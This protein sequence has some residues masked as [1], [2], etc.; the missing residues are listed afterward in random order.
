MDALKAPAL[1]ARPLEALCLAAMLTY[2]LQRLIV[3]AA[4]L[5]VASMVVFAVIEI[6][7]GNA[8]Q[9]LLGATATPEAV[10]ALAHQARS[11]SAGAVRYAAWIGGALHG[12]FG[13]SYAYRTPIA[14]MI[15]ASLMISAPLAALAMAISAAIALARASTPP[16][17][18]GAPATRW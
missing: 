15:G 2:V 16:T 9:T 18:A 10:A 11:R 4:T 17:G 8:A 5:V 6:L 13:L 1:V 14:P 3:L 12:D 7:P